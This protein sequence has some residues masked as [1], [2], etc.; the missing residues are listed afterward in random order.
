MKKLLVVMLVLAMAGMANAAIQLS[1]NGQDA[2]STTETTGT[3]TIFGDTEVDQGS[4]ILGI[5]TSSVGTGTL[6]ATSCVVN[7]VGT[8][9]NC[10]N[11]DDADTA[12]MVS[13]YNPF[14][15]AS[16]TDTLEPMDPVVGTLVTNIAY[17]ATGPGDVIFVLLSG[18]DG[19]L[20][21]QFTVT[22]PEPITIGLLGLGGLF[23]RRRK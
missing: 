17:T 23:L 14:V 16:L 1:V 5:L 8:G 9:A 15:V 13:I 6:D 19:S 12:A 3:I 20:L 2:I 4:F 21:S 18:S 11:T 10:L 7:Y 22:T